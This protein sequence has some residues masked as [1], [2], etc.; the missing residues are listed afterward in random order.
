[1]LRCSLCGATVPEDS[2]RWRCSCGAPLDADFGGIF[3]MNGSRIRSGEQGMWR[4]GSSLPLERPEEKVSFGEG[5]TPLVREEWNGLNLFLKLDFVCPT[6]SYK[7]RGMAYLVSRLRELGVRE[8]IEDSSGNAGASMAAYCARAGIACRVFVP[9]YTSEGKCV[10]VS[11]YGALLERIPGTRE[12]TARA[13]EKAAETVFY[14]GHNWSPWFAH[15]IKTFAFELWE[16]LGFTAPEAVLLPAGQG[17]LVL[18]CALAFDELHASGEIDTPPRI[19]AL[20]PRNCAPL[21]DAF[22]K[23][24]SSPERVEKRETIAE[25]ISSAEP[26]RGREVLKAVKKTGGDILSFSDREIWDGCVELARRGYF[27]EPTSAIVA[28][29]AERLS[30]E[31]GVGRKGPVAAVLTGSGLKGSSK[32]LSLFSSPP[33]D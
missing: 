16:Q 12:D 3:P 23:G 6:G 30:R 11:S 31:G 32:I 14:A 26:V 25:G 20:Q 19:F 21:E 29:A 18:G 5:W 10:Q 9:D 8:V 15:G 17:S 33:E 28:A 4:Y 2:L 22:R 27:V 13:A 7:D 24:R 1:M